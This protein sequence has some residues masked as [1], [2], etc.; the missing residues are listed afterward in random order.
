MKGV[1]SEVRCGQPILAT[2]L[3]QRHYS[4]QRRN[5]LRPSQKSCAI[6]ECSGAATAKGWCGKH[7]M[8]WKRHG[9]S[10]AVKRHGMWVNVHAG[11]PEAERFWI[12]VE[13]TPTCW[14]WLGGLNGTGY[15]VFA[16]EP[17]R[18]NGRLSLVGAHRYAYQLL[19]GEIPEGLHLDHLCRNPACVNPDHLEVVTP[20][21]NT[22]RGIGPSANN[23][24]KIRCKEGHFFDQVNT[25]VD[26]K[27]GHRYC[28][29]CS[30]RRFREWYRRHRA[31]ANAL[32]SEIELAGRHEP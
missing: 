17:R 24:Q 4:Q 25:W 1:C 16:C 31:R 8:R 30:R 11:I 2:G 14:S 28:R 18:E 9:D 32:R 19:R 23:H 7:Y 6:A 13:K 21:I 10:E 3:C 27:T 29:E 12:K 26:P 22:L 5:G 15:G 20:Q